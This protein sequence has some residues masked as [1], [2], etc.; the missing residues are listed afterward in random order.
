MI[1]SS[2]LPYPS[3]SWT[4]M[5]WTMLPLCLVVSIVYKTVR[6]QRLQRLWREIPYMF[7]QIIAGL[8]ALGAAAWIIVNY[9][10]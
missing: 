2:L 1:L 5:F 4:M 7:F 3:V 6:I 8:A 10:P 9:W